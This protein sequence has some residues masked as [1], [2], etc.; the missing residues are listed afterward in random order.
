METQWPRQ[1]ACSLSQR[2]CLW[3]WTAPIRLLTQVLSC[4]GMW[5]ISTKLLGYCWGAPRTTRGPS[6]KGSTPLSIRAAAPSICRSRQ[7]S[8]QTL[9]CTTVLSATQ[10]DRLQRKLH[11]NQ[12]CRKAEWGRAC[13]GVYVL[14]LKWCSL[15][16]WKTPMKHRPNSCKGRCL[17]LFWQYRIDVNARKNPGFDPQK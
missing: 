3:C 15:A 13:E 12:G 9:P 11:M 7:Y 8:C 14:S 2:G 10:W 17:W 4:S 6:T 1:K 5:S 16:S